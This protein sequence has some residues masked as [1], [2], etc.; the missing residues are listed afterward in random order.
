MA[1]WP[2]GVPGDAP[3]DRQ[4]GEVPSPPRAPERERPARLPEPWRLPNFTLEQGDGLALPVPAGV[5]VE[6]MTGADEAGITV[7]LTAEGVRLIPSAAGDFTLRVAYNG[8]QQ[9]TVLWTVN[10]DPWSLWQVCQPPDE[11][12]V[13]ADDRARRDVDNHRDLV[14]RRLP[15]MTLLGASR[16]GRSHEHAGSFRDDDLGV[17]ADEARGNALLLVSDGAGSCRFSREG[18]RRIIRFITQRAEENKERLEAAWQAEAVLRPEGA[19]GMILAQLAAKAREALQQQVAAEAVAHPDWTL[20]DFSATLLMA[21]V[22]WEATGGLRV[23]SFSIGDGAIAW[24]GAR[25]G[26]GL[27]SRA[28]YGEFS[29]GTR[30]LTSPDVWRSVVLPEGRVPWNWQTFCR[31]R[32]ACQHFEPEAARGLRL[33]LMTDGISDPWFETEQGLQEEARWRNFADE[34]LRGLAAEAQPAEQAER[35]WQWLGFRSAGNHDDRTLLVLTVD[36]GEA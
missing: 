28:D 25:E 34:A 7:Q 11:A 9:A 17:W 5:Q 4:P 24:L 12:L 3:T 10:P 32:V 6:A 21:A 26:F 1:Q 36:G 22:K 13:F 27:M 23:V 30:F 14:A 35:L 2:I 19:V 31:A 18:A 33:F 8:G 16:R 20:K 29:G 15:G